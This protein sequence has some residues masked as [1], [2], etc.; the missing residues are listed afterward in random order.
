VVSV[1]PWL[2]MQPSAAGSARVRVAAII[3]AATT[4]QTGPQAATAPLVQ[5][6]QRNT[7]AKLAWPGRNLDR[8]AQIPAMRS[9]DDG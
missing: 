7:P 6:L 2:W 8:Y 1:R 9:G 3:A 5:R 4:A